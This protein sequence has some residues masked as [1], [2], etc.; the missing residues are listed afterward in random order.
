MRI[1][2][3]LRFLLLACAA[4]VLFGPHSGRAEEGVSM[5]DPDY[6]FDRAGGDYRNF[7]L[8]TSDPTLCQDACAA[9][10]KCRAWA[11]VKPHTVQGPRPV[12][13]LKDQ[14]FNKRE[15]AHCVSGVK[16]PVPA[17]SR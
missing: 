6:G 1:V 17:P 3:V 12:C 2:P 4:L 10:P 9:D 8:K 5:S 16:R 11:Y 15:V 7:E 14:V 13:W